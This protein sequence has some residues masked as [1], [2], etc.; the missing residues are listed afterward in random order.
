METF[1]VNQK[2]SIQEI[3]QRIERACN[4]CEKDFTNSVQD[5]LFAFDGHPLGKLIHLSMISSDL[6][7]DYL[8]KIALEMKNWGSK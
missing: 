5:C 1:T 2:M 4:L 7:F 8:R 3:G 6:D